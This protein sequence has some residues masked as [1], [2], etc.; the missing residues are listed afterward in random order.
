MEEH[1][2]FIYIWRDRDRNMYYIGSHD[3]SPNDG[4]IS[5]SRWF[6]GEYRYRP[7]AFRRKVLKIL[8]LSQLR[9][10]EASL[11][12]LI[13]EKEFGQRYYNIKTGRSKGC[14]TWN[15]GKKL[16]EE[17]K[18]A[19]SKGRKGQPAWNKDLPNPHA[20]D[21]GKKSAGKLK[22]K[23]IGRRMSIVNGKRTWI[24]PKNDGPEGP[25]P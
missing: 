11:L 22:A 14:Q 19:I 9:L 24:Y 8:P 13:Q 17:Y 1:F 2:G 3:G 12:K 4:Y 7:Q 6:N 23:A 18:A 21:N 16:S 15:A 25:S 20:A 10:A 5:S